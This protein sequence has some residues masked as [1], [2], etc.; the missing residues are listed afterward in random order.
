M[1]SWILPIWHSPSALIA[2]LRRCSSGL[3]TAMDSSPELRVRAS[4]IWI[5][6]GMASSAPNC[7]I[8]FGGFTPL[9]RLSG[10]FSRSEVD[11]VLC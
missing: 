3:M 5:E 10:L 1:N 4:E 7:G 8:H 11:R 6:V 2:A 9:G